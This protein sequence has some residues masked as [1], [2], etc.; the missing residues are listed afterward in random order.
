[1]DRQVMFHS[2]WVDWKNHPVTRLFLNEMISQVEAEIA[3][4]ATGA[5]VNPI[6]DRYQVGKIAGIGFAVDWK[7]QLSED[8]NE[9]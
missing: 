3:A 2:Q 4:L 1:M 7:P 5:G 9:V 8:E 6:Q